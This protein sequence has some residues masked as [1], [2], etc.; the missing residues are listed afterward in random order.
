MKTLAVALGLVLVSVTLGISS[1]RPE[2]WKMRDKFHQME[3]HRACVVSKPDSL[4]DFD[5]LKYD[6]SIS[7]DLVAQT[8]TGTTG[9]LI[10]SEVADLDSIFL[11]LVQLTVDSI[12]MMDRNL[13]FGHSAGVIEIGLDST[14]PA[15]DT[16]QVNI[17]YQGHPAHEAWG[18]FWFTS[19]AAFNLG[20][21]LNTDPPSMGRYWFPCYDVPNDKAEFDMSY[22]V[23]LGKVA[24][25]NGILV[26]TIPDYPE[27]TM[28][29]VWSE[30]HPTSTYLVAVSISD[31]VVVPDSVYAWIYNYVYPEDSSKA[32]TSFRNVHRMMDAYETFFSPYHFDK[33]S[34][35]ETPKG[36]MEHQTC[37][38]HYYLCINGGNN[39]DWLL[40]HEL[41]HQ[42][43]GDWVTIADW[44]DIWLNEGF[45]TYCE[46]IYQ[47]YIGG[48]NAYHNYV[49]NSIMNYYLASGELF[50]IYDPQEMWGAT[51]YEK[52]ASVLHML[53]HVI[54]D[55][56]FFDALNS[57]GDK[58][59]YGNV[60]TPNFQAV[61]ESV[62]GQDLD[63]FFDQWIYD[64]EYPKYVYSYWQ[65]GVDTVRVVVTQEQTIGP[66]FVMPVDFRVGTSTGD[67]VVVGWVD[68][69]PES[70]T[71]AFEGANTDSFAFDPDD[72]ILK[73]VRNEPGIAER[74][75]AYGRQGEKA[76]IAV[77]P[78]PFAR[79]IK[80]TLVS[81]MGTQSEDAVSLYIYDI[82]G[83]LVKT[84]HM[85]GDG[86]DSGEVA[87][88]YCHTL[89]WDGKDDRGN[90]LPS[91]VYFCRFNSRHGSVSSK[92]IFLR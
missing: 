1:E 41:S 83:Q 57:Y 9:V 77:S 51:S 15:G 25:S 18:G 91:G 4:H 76:H 89:V 33:F 65:S 78:N 80:L 21:G 87:P 27:S 66:V 8:L 44:R 55:S 82:T 90:G 64:W 79:S 72:W 34:F 37:V 73:L 23:P 32:V 81:K 62:Y 84:F 70:L 14:I 74:Q 36:D 68:E 39:Y 54:T 22:T 46:A 2:R 10:R 61:C 86:E 13:P 53:R 20:V 58:Y 85:G 28:T 71:F 43:W 5:V 50:P 75:N 3:A 19:K 11:H 69:S 56:I 63:W 17:A 16:F 67:T 26:D 45:A 40:A 24:V 12:W 48:W 7:F 47:E 31:Y 6:L 42:W 29:Y 92:L 59:A 60:V 30:H 88:G 49:V 35:V 38:S 52:G